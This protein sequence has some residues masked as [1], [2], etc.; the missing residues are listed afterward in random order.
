M[1]YI[2]KTDTCMKPYNSKKWWIMRDYIKQITV[3]A[4]SADE[5]LEKWREEVVNDYCVE[6]TRNGMKHKQPMYRDRKDGSAKQVGW[7]ITGR[8]EFMDDEK[9]R[10][11]KQYIDLWVEII[12]V[13]DTDFGE[14]L[15][16]CE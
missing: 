13:V 12:T 14:D 5:A 11:S 15:Q 9:Y 2:I 8:S 16:E 7:V 3:E 10:W 1:E 6:I 4:G